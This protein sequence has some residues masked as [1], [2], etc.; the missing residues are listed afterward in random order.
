MKNLTTTI[1]LCL[2]CFAASNAQ[3]V[4]INVLEGADVTL[5]GEFFT[6]GWMGGDVPADAQARA[7]SLVDG[8]FLPQSSQWD[9]NT[10]W[11]DATQ[12]AASQNNYIM[13]DLGASFYIESFIVQADDNDS[14]T[15]EYWDGDSWELAMD[16]AN[17]D[18]YGWGLQT[19]P[20]PGN[21]LQQ[22]PLLP[23]PFLT[24]RL[25]FSGNNY[26]GDGEFAVSEIQAFGYAAEV[27]EPSSLLLMGLGMLGFVAPSLKKN[28]RLK[29]KLG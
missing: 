13:L 24:D 20:N 21:D 7:N 29:R 9:Q 19:R 27:P 5:Q 15:L 18:P 14:Y 3:A 2:G 8:V 6:G 23:I 28:Y 4:S 16:I 25:R 22:T 17:Y 11:W 26:D 12:S 1:L 10:V